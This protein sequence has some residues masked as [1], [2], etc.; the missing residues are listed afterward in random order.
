MTRHAGKLEDQIT[1]LQAS[2]Q[3]EITR[4]EEI[5]AATEA[6]I[7]KNFPIEQRPRSSCI[8]PQRPS[9][10]KKLCRR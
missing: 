2:E 10:E 6:E 3:T 8:F 7:S 5:I 4:Q 1:A 9:R